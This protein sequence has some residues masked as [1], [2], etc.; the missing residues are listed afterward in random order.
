EHFHKKPGSTDVGGTS[1][2]ADDPNHQAQIRSSIDFTDD[3]SWDAALR[4][5]G[6]LHN[7]A[8]QEYAELNTRLAWRVTPKLELS[9][10][11]FNLLH[12]RHTEFIEPGI[13]DQVPRSFF[14]EA[15]VR[16]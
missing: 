7:P 10:S 6:K 13:A 4:Y 12:A 5:V 14:V 1:F 9:L 16:F 11:G 8:V 3:V 2:V 15:R